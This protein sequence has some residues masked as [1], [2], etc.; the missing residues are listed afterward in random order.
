MSPPP[1]IL[2]TPGLENNF[3]K[4]R[5]IRIFPKLVPEDF[6][7]PILYKGLNFWSQRG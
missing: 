5:K 3:G 7:L 6:G 2:Y 4:K 1:V